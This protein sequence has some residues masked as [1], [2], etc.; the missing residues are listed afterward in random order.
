MVSILIWISLMN[1]QEPLW[2][3][4]LALGNQGTEQLKDMLGRGVFFSHS[5]SREAEARHSG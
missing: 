3:M 4:D 2:M 5:P 1:Q